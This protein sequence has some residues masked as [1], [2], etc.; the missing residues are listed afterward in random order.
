M[1]TSQGEQCGLSRRAGERSGKQWTHQLARGELWER[2]LFFMS[3]RLMG[4]GGIWSFKKP[5]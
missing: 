5:A 3:K 4:G 1:Q 2:H